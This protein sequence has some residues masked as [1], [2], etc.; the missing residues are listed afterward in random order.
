MEI[1]DNLPAVCQIT[2]EPVSSPVIA[3]GRIIRAAKKYSRAAATGAF[4]LVLAGGDY[5]VTFAGGTSLTVNVPD[6]GGTYDFI[7]RITSNVIQATPSDP[8]ATPLATT[9]T[10]GRVKIDV[11]MN[12]PVVP[13]MTTFA[14]TAALADV[15]LRYVSDQ[16]ALTASAPASVKLALLSATIGGVDVLQFWKWDEDSGL[17]VDGVTVIAPTGFGGDV[18]GRY[19]LLGSVALAV[20]QGVNFRAIGA[21]LQLLSQTGSWFVPAGALDP[22][23]LTLALA[24]PDHASANIRRRGGMLEL[25]FDDGG[26]RAPFLTGTADVPVLAFADV[27]AAPFVNDHFGDSAWQLRNPAIDTYHTWFVT[28]TDDAPTISFAAAS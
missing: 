17:P 10:A 26:W 8:D 11:A 15:S 18:P 14:V 25:F 6:D 9:A 28:G 19:L 20:P 7:E 1:S 22:L 27:G 21:Q 13:T 4:A 16:A 5:R 2:V 24:S 3:S 12:P 23:G